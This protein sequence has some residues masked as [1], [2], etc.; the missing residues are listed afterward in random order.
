MAKLTPLERFVVENVR[1]MSDDDLLHLVRGALIHHMPSALDAVVAPLPPTRY[2]PSPS[3]P[4]D[5][6]E[7]TEDRILE[8]LRSDEPGE[9]LSM[10]Q[11]EEC[12]GGVG[13]ST[14]R[15]AVRRLEAKGRVRRTGERRFTR[16][17]T[18]SAG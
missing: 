7:K 12:A 2:A 15:T 1:Q 13:T 5:A 8:A 9:G 11:L 10:R 18:A 16:Y 4:R 6:M 3:T 17:F 14:V